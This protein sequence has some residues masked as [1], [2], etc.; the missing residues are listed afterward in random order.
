[1]KRALALIL[2][3]LLAFPSFAFADEDIINLDDEVIIEDLNVGNELDLYGEDTELPVIDQPDIMPGGLEIDL[4]PGLDSND[5][6]VP[7]PFDQT[8]TI[9]DIVF[10]LTA[11]L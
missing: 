7:V 3:I 4:Q 6:P 8:V 11:A 1:M 10:T 2:A 9:D 5:A